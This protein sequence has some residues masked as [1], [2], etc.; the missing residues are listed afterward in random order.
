[1]ITAW[2]R[3]RA[4]RRRIRL[5]Q[6]P[7]HPWHNSFNRLQRCYERRHVVVEAF[8]DLADT[9]ITVRSPDP[10]GLDYPPLGHTTPRDVH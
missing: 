9:I 5:G 3:H 6:D 10:P 8:F 4:P 2:P 1:L 7:R